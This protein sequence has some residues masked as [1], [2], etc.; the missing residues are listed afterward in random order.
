MI[1]GGQRGQ[2]C[3]H[4]IEVWWGFRRA[5]GGEQNDLGRAALEARAQ[6]A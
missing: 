4:E 2:K 1:K 5:H 3:Q 6:A